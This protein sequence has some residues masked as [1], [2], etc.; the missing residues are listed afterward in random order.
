MAEITSDVVDQN[1][2]LFRELLDCEG[3]IYHWIYASH[4]HLA[5]TNCPRLVLSTV[6]EHSGGLDFMEKTFTQK[7]DKNEACP[8]LILG[9]QLGLQWAASIEVRGNVI[10]YH[11]IGPVKSAELS[12]AAFQEAARELNI[13]MFWRKDFYQL[14]DNLPVAGNIMFVRYALMLHYCC[15]MEKVSRSDVIYQ[16]ASS[17]SGKTNKSPA[18]PGDRNATYMAEQALLHCVR[19]GN[20]NYKSALAKAGQ[21]SNG[22]RISAK[23]PTLQ[24]LISTTS[25]TS[26]CVRAAI[27][28]GMSPDTAYMVGDQYIQSMVTTTSISELASINHAM[29]EDFIQRVHRAKENPHYSKQIQ[30]CCEYIELHAEDELKLSDIANKVGYAEYYLSRKFKYEV[31]VSVSRYIRTVR[32]ER[33]KNLLVTTNQPINEIASRLHFSSSSHFSDVFREITG[34]LPQHYRR[35]EQRM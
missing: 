12:P 29:L 10:R 30:A 18:L 14:L 7:R 17:L 4:G 26:L 9:G 15:T 25:F 2:A 1:L 16:D 32:V 21:I 27:E 35:E 8:P 34:R 24:A 28:S 6:F 5:E 33:A 3:K 31:G 20:L 22:V 13:D 11:V 23:S 19:E